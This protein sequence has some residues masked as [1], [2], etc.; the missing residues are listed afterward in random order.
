MKLDPVDVGDAGE[1]HQGRG[2][3]HPGGGDRQAGADAAG[4]ADAADAGAERL[5]GPFRTNGGRGRHAERDDHDRRK[6]SVHGPTLGPACRG[7]GQL[8]GDSPSVTFALWLA[9]G[10][11]GPAQGHRVAGLVASRAPTAARRTT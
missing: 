4:R 9:A 7:P 10:G 11:V 6:K 1:R 5:T 8:T 2:D 3:Q